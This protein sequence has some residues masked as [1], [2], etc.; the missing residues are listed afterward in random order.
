MRLRIDLGYD[1]SGFHGWARQ[2]GLRTVQGEVEHA[3]DL[4]LRTTGTSLTVAGRTDTG[5]HA[6]GQVVHLDV[7]PDALASAGAEARSRPPRRWFAGSTVC[8]T[9]TYAS[10]A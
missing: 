8:W 10:T 4:V 9:P 1:G 3:L 2:P 5:V 7:A 6:R